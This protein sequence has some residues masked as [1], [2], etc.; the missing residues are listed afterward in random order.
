MTDPKRGPFLTTMA[1]LFSVLAVSNATKFL[2][3]LN[4][5]ETNGFVLF[6]YRFETLVSNLIFGLLFA[7]ILFAYARGIWTM[8]RWVLPLS[9]AYAFYVPTNL[10]LF[11]YLRPPPD[12]PIIGIIVYLVFALGGSI[13]TALYLSA[14]RDRLQ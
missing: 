11:W 7:G 14:H 1:V 6:G 5:P 4:S 13:G 12:R 3:S 2:Q 8:K 10:V 9:A